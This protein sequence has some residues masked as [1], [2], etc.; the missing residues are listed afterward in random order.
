VP[1][2]KGGCGRWVLAGCGC[3]AL[4]IIVLVVFGF[5]FDAMQLYCVSPLDSMFRE[6][7]IPLLNNFGFNLSLPCP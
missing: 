5:I 3:L 4:V 7:I 1:E 6:F 2:K